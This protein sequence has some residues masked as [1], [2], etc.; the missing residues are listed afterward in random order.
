MALDPKSLKLFIRVI[1]AGT[2]SAAAEQEHIAAA[3]ISR[4]ISDLEEQMGVALVERSNKG[5]KATPAGRALIDRAHRILNDL[6]AL[7]THIQD[8]GS[9]EKGYVRIHANL[10]AINQFLPA[11]LGAF[12][13]SYPHIQIDLAE[14]MSTE[15]AQAVAENT[16]DI[17]VLVMDEPIK[18]LTYSPYRSDELAIITSRHHPLAKRRKVRFEETLDFP[19]VGLPHGSQMNLQLT[20]SALALNRTW[21]CRFQVSGYDALCLMVEADLGTGILPRRVAQTQAKAL[22]I[23]ILELD[24]PWAKRQLHLCIRSRASLSPA[25][26]LLVAHMAHNYVSPAMT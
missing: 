14:R 13:K 17:G 26:Q 4:R 7:E 15:I 20:R 9:G 1:Q 22:H 11:E 16:A 12:L 24:E 8:Y 18:D 2:I 23:R 25:A 10:S 19:Y 5:L 6:G 21:R 3:A